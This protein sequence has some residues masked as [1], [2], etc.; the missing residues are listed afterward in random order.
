VSADLRL[1]RYRDFRVFLVGHITS[2]LGSAMSTPATAFAVLDSGGGAAALGWVMAAGIVPQ[3]VF[4]LPGGVAAD[5]LGHRRMML[6][7]DAARAVAQGA[8]ALVLLAGHGHAEPW[9]FL[10]AALVRGGGEAFFRPAFS[11][12]TPDIAPQPHLVRANALL[13]TARSSAAVAG[14]ALAGVLVAVT[15]PALVLAVDAASYLVSVAALTALRTPP[16]VPVT[17]GRRRELTEGWREFRSR[18]WLAATTAHLSV[19]NLAVWGPFLLLGPVLLDRPGGGGAGAWGCVM[20]AYGAGSIL[21]GLLAREVRYPLRWATLGALGYGL[22]CA[23]LAAGAAPGWTAAGAAVAGAGSSLSAAFAAT[24]TQQHVP[25]RALARVSSLQTLGTFSLGPLGLVLAGPLAH[26]LGASRLLWCSAA[27]CAAVALAVLARRDV[28][29]QAVSR[30]GA[31]DGPSVGQGQRGGAGGVGE[32]VQGGDAAGLDGEG[33]DGQDTALAEGDDAGRAVDQDDAALGREAGEGDRLG[34]DLGRAAA[35][36]AREERAAVA[37]GHHVRV[38]D[39]QQGL[40]VAG[41]GGGQEGVHDAALAGVVRVGRRGRALDAAAGPAGEL[42]GRD[43]GAAEDRG[44]V[45]EGH[46]EHVA[47]GRRS[48]ASPTSACTRSWPGGRP[49]SSPTRSAP[50]WP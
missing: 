39:G 14:P 30:D 11:A 13:G 21:G 25:R 42:A 8:L 45:V 16:P 17:K 1:L 20:A 24:A 27:V 29:R 3:L 46:V 38:E 19:V 35:Q 26:I 50:P 9:L 2:M 31:G 36:D 22:P 32:D 15:G 49:R 47:H 40:E 5:R 33:H 43:H 18:R 34:G 41:A 4:L 48:T 37:A 7:A 12:L 6:A 23:L 28:R 44:D 10:V